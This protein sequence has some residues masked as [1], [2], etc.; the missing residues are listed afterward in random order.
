MGWIVV[1]LNQEGRNKRNQEKQ[2]HNLHP[3]AVP[4]LVSVLSGFLLYFLEELPRPFARN[5]AG[6]FFLEIERV[7]P[8]VRASLEPTWGIQPEMGWIV[9]TLNQEGRNKRNQEKQGH[10]L[11][12][13]P[14]LSW[15]PFFLDS[16]SIFWRNYPGP[17][18]QARV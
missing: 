10:N 9:V 11:H 13:M 14:F 3:N 5:Q 6:Y 7:Y 12:Q 2:G 4:F 8:Q 15:F 16:C 18:P 17:S 1:T